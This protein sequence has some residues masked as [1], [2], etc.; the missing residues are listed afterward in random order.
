MQMKCKLCGTEIPADDTD[1]EKA[2]STCAS[3]QAV[4]AAESQPGGALH[5]SGPARPPEDLLL[6]RQGDVL[7][8]TWPVAWGGQCVL[9]VLSVGLPG[10]MTLG[11]FTTPWESP[12]IGVAATLGFLTATVGLGYCGLAGL[13][14]RTHLVISGD[15][16]KV[17]TRGRIRWLA[18]RVIPSH[19][20][21]Q[22]YCREHGGDRSNS[23][24]TYSLRVVLK[25]GEKRKLIS[26]LSNG[27][28]LYLEREIEKRIGIEDRPVRGESRKRPA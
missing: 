7:D 16:V 1:T 11:A 23:P 9:F 20:I 18:D 15:E 21:E 4:V 12:L 10:A 22:L 5:R 8:I 26:G 19:A 14:N 27:A 17:E 25:D 6:D 3:C 28:A 2:A 13:L 24:P